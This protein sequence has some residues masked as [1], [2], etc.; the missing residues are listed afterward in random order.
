[1]K[2]VKS[3]CGVGVNDVEY[4]IT[5]KESYCVDGKRRRRVI[6]TCPYY[7]R[8]VGML[9][10][11]YNE[12]TQKYQPTYT[13]CSVDP[14]WHRFSSFRLWMSGQDWEGNDLDKDLLVEGNKV[15][16]PDTCIFVPP[17]VNLFIAH[18]KASEAGLPSGV[19]CES[20]IKG[21]FKYK[22]SVIYEGKYKS[23][24]KYNTVEEAHN[25]YLKYKQGIAYELAYLQKDE[26][27][28]SALLCRYSDLWVASELD[29]YVSGSFVPVAIVPTS[30]T[31]CCAY[32][33]S[34]F[35]STRKDAKSCSQSCG[36]YLRVK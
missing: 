10:R 13:D 18:R 34:Q 6:W 28:T 17:E 24:G 26:R 3:V 30:Y 22:A 19:T 11:C 16:G 15:Y 35:T 2:A 4:A 31:K 25:A 14:E 12:N 20:T 9:S 8:W 27:I 32:C 36:R 21:G 33:N 29:S 23:V 1:M 7:V 5:K